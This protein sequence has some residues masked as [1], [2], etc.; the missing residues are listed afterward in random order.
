MVSKEAID[1]IHRILQEREFRLSCDK[2]RANDVL[3]G[4]PVSAQF[5]YSMDPRYRQITSYFVHPNDATDIKSHPFFRGI[6]WNELHLNQPPLVPRVRN[7]EDTRYF[8]DWKSIGHWDEVSVG[9]ESEEIEDEEGN[10]TDN[11]DLAAEPSQIPTSP[12]QAEGEQAP[13]DADRISPVEL[14]APK[15]DLLKAQE[16]EKKK[17]RKRPR[18]KILRDKRLS[19]AALEIRKRGAFLG[20]TYRRPRGPAL[21]LGT[22]RGRQHV[23]RGHLVDMYA[24]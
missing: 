5:L 14:T 11:P 1:L 4:R 16:A 9:S 8:D 21:A 2:Y 10:A 24:P 17:E 22:E 6:R 20:Y 19:R 23:G 15:A 18:D 12:N 7:W 13:T 3:I